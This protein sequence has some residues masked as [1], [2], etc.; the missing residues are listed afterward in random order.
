MRAPFRTQIVFAYFSKK[1]HFNKKTFLFTTTQ[2]TILLFFLKLSFSIFSSFRFCFIQHKKTK[3]STFFRNPF[4]D[5]STTFKTIFRTPIHYLCFSWYSQNTIKLG[6]KLAKTNL[7]QIFDSTLA[8]F[9]TQERPNLGQILTPQHA[10]IKTHT[11]IYIYIWRLTELVPTFLGLKPIFPPKTKE[12]TAKKTRKNFCDFFFGFFCVIVDKNTI[13]IGVS[14]DFCWKMAKKLAKR[15]FRAFCK[16]HRLLSA[17]ML[18]MLNHVGCKPPKKR[19]FLLKCWIC[20][21][22]W[23]FFGP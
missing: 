1:C 2:N 7:G 14:W 8:R 5:T 19:F 13:E 18:N 3:K 12:K 21:I 15:A 4:F 16:C 10:Y 22:C 17:E 23:M 9:L 20:W 11:H 6:E